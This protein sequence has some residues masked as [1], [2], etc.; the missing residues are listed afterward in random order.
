M[1]LARLGAILETRV[2]DGQQSP[3]IPT[4]FAGRKE[5][6]EAMPVAVFVHGG[7]RKRGEEARSVVEHIVGG[8]LDTALLRELRELMQVNVV[9]DGM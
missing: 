3:N 4:C 6:E 9:P 5:R 2:V 7:S 8:G 1:L